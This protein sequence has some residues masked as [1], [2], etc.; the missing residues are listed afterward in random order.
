MIEAKNCL[1]IYKYIVL[2][3]YKQFFLKDFFLLFIL[4]NVIIKKH[5]FK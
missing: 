5:I 4:S 1:Q 3:I 2:L